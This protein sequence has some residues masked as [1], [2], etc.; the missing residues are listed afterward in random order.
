MNNDYQ[1]WY[2]ESAY[3]AAGQAPARLDSSLGRIALKRE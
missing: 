1:L 2:V 3:E